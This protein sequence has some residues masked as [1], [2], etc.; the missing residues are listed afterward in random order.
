[1]FSSV[2]MIL[3]RSTPLMVSLTVPFCN[4]GGKKMKGREFS[5][6]I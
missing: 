4:R 6:I 1:M 3:G 2:F 5:K